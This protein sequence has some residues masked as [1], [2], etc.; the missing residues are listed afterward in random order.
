MNIRPPSIR[1][2]VSPQLEPA[3]L[4]TRSSVVGAVVQL[5]KSSLLLNGYALVANTGLTAALGMAFWVLAA[6]L[7][8][9]E[10]VG[11]GGVAISTMMSL[12]SFAQ[13]NFGNILVRFVPSAGRG[14]GRLI[15]FSFAVGAVVSVVAGGVFLLF[16]NAFMPQ[17]GVLTHELRFAFLFV[18]A[19]M[20]WTI[21]AL[22]DSAL[23]G[24]RQSVWVPLENTGYAL[25]KIALVVLL[26]GTG[27]GWQA[28]LAAWTLPIVVFV[29]AVNFLIFG[30]L[31][32][33][34]ARG[35]KA[36]QVLDRRSVARFFGWDYVCAISIMA[37]WI[38]TPLLVLNISGA[39]AS[40]HFYVAWTIFTSLYYVG[41]SM[42]TSL[43]AE[44]ASDKSRLH[45]LAADAVVL[46]VL[47]LAGFAVAV[48]VFAP[49]IMGLFGASY[50]TGGASIL[51]LF[52]LASLPAGLVALYL[53][54]ARTKGWMASV[55]VVGFAVFVLSQGIGAILL[56][57][58][59]P[60]GM[61]VGWLAAYLMILAGIA[62]YMIIRSGPQG[63]VDGLLALARSS[64]GLAAH[65]RPHR[66]AP[67]FVMPSEQGLLSLLGQSG[68][69]EAS[70]WRPLQAE[71]GPDL[72]MIYLGKP[73]RSGLLIGA[74]RAQARAVLKVAR[75]P[76]AIRMLEQAAAKSA[77]LRAEARRHKLAFEIPQIL[78][79]RRSHETVESLEALA[80]G[81]GGAIVLRNP[82]QRPAA[83]AVVA[84]AIG[85]MH[86][87]AT[88]GAV[89][90][91]D[92]IGEWLELP[93]RRLERAAQ[94]F[95]PSAQRHRAIEAFLGEQR[96]F[97]H[98]YSRL[99]WCHG[100]LDASKITFSTK[101]R[102]ARKHAPAKPSLAGISG[103]DRA[104]SDAPD[105][106]D[107]CHFALSMRMLLRGSEIGDVAREL[108]CAGCWEAE[109]R[110]WLLAGALEGAASSAWVYDERATRARV[111]LAWLNHVA[112][113]LEDTVGLCHS[114]LWVASNVDRVLV[115]IARKGAHP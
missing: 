10:A 115:D 14:A 5:L 35:Q 17:F 92:W 75:G 50:V 111:G 53:A 27:W 79:I 84:R 25:A 82:V 11:I 30:W 99:G 70:D 8:P 40:A 100:A 66:A 114:R 93:A 58:Y 28:L 57:R 86:E 21:F 52:A 7:Y 46:T 88:A 63:V 109:E 48:V 73:S 102:R 65:F 105:G 101:V 42:G 113:R 20:L 68:S 74:K 1:P 18:A 83:L 110:E 29:I 103:W 107:A 64:A 3:G 67:V 26:A 13:L 23:S 85:D 37:A 81:E 12:S 76:G 6:R 97:W 19:T 96:A 41:Q 95:L 39:T 91:E 60:I 78:A 44:G 56:Y 104:R 61:A 59:G 108:V 38:C 94:T 77:E 43:L 90:G 112:A 32:P 33:A 31:L 36:G 89:V 69:P 72:D 2:D 71:A 55:A 51:R 45:L 87:R 34:H 54:F 15:L 4:A 22:Q 80:E 24:L 9:Q 47:P 16:A 49:L 62:V 98:G 106:F